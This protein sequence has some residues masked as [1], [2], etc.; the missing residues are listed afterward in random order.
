MSSPWSSGCRPGSWLRVL[1]SRKL[2]PKRGQNSIVLEGSRFKRC[3]QEYSADRIAPGGQ[4]DRKLPRLANGG[5]CDRVA[6]RDA[7]AVGAADFENA[8]CR[9]GWG[10]GCVRGAAFLHIGSLKNT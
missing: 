10:K 3:R 8:A 4:R 7:S 5:A 6:D 1:K 2:S 9:N